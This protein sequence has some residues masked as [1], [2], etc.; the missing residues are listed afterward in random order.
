MIML[1][2]NMEWSSLNVKIKTR[3]KSRFNYKKT[4]PIIKFNITRNNFIKM[5]SQGQV[6][7]IQIIPKK[8]K[9]KNK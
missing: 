8:T 6:K 7:V 5:I 3:N 2:W 9:K 4:F 1:I